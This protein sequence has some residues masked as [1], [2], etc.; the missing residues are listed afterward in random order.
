MARIPPTTNGNSSTDVP[1][2]LEYPCTI[3][4][5]SQATEHT[6]ECDGTCEGWEPTE[7]QVKLQNLAREF[8]REG[9]PH[10]GTIPGL[11]IP[12]ITVDPV[13][14]VCR[15]LVLEQFMFGHETIDREEFDEMFRAKKVEF[16]IEILESNRE[17]VRKRRITDSLG[18]VK[19]G[20]LGPNGQPI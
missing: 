12:G 16:L 5:C 1:P 20:L 10:N 9:M 13:D 2:D 4:E 6:I 7:N 3:Y 15:L 11:P 18:I 17:R 14:L 8:A 19:P